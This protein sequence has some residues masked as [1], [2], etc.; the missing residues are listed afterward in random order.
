MV[1]GTAFRAILA[2]HL[3]PGDV[4]SLLG[5]LDSAA[6]DAARVAGSIVAEDP[7]LVVPDTFSRPC[8]RRPA[9]RRSRSR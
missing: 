6:P 1:G 4:D 5:L 8:R 9:W 3:A 2:D 7:D